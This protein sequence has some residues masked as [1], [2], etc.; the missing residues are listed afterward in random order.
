[1]FVVNGDDLNAAERG[2]PDRM[3]QEVFAF[4]E[5]VFTAGENA[6]LANQHDYRARE[7]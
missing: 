6:P 4:H 1:M 3:F 2:G 5:L 7:K